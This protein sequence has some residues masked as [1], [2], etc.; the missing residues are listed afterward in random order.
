[1]F[2]KPRVLAVKR[3]IDPEEYLDLMD[4]EDAGNNTMVLDA[5]PRPPQDDASAQSSIPQAEIESSAPYQ[6]F[7]TDKRVAIYEYAPE[8]PST[9]QQVA[10]V[11]EMLGDSLQLEKPKPSKSKRKA[12]PSFSPA[13]AP[14]KDTS[15]WVFGQ[16]IEATRLDLGHYQITEE[17][18]FN[19]STDDTRALPPSAIERERVLQR[20]GENEEQIVVTTRR[21]RGAGRA[22]DTDDDGF[23]EDDCEVLDF[24]DQRV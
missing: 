16:P 19:M 9:A 24:A 1:M 10:L 2:P 23:F 22:A 12:S 8:Q 6:P 3:I 7:H 20:F 17:E 18:S 15:V 14:V 5:R 4:R 13:Q 11:S 21:R